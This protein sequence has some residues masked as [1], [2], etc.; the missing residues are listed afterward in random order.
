M[1]KQGTLSGS[2]SFLFYFSLAFLL[3][4]SLVPLSAP[5]PRPAFV[6]WW[7]PLTWTAVGVAWSGQ[8][9][10]SPRSTRLFECLTV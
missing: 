10:K 2:N 4:L 8:L 3:S 9:K 7:E 5:W 6:S 1:D